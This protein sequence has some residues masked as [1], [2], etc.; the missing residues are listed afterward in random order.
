MAGL[1]TYYP[2]KKTTAP[3][4]KKELPVAPFTTLPD[5]MTPQEERAH[6]P[7][8]KARRE[9]E[10]DYGTV[11]QSERRAAAAS[12][13][14]QEADERHRSRRLDYDQEIAAVEE[15]VRQYRKPTA[16]Y[17]P[18][19]DSISAA[20]TVAR[21]KLPPLERMSPR[22]EHDPGSHKTKGG[23]MARQSRAAE[24]RFLEEFRK[25][26]EER[27]AAKNKALLEELLKKKKGGK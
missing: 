11:A 19:R 16:V 27:A 12:A 25:P 18:S 3:R 8:G 6:N 26:K 22:H 14:D 21:T 13:A 4:K 17:A 24:A 23:A 5:D 10:R 2:K 15:L 20:P 9:R 7:P 1:G